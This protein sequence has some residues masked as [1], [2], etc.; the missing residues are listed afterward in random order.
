MVKAIFFDVLGT[1]VDWNRGLSGGFDRAFAKSGKDI[2]ASTLATAWYRT[3]RA[4]LASSAGAIQA[5]E[6]LAESL[7][8]VLADADLEAPAGSREQEL[9]L[10]CWQRFPAWPDSV[11]G[12]R[13]LRR[14][15]V[16]ASCTD[17]PTAPMTWLAKHAGLPWDLVLGSDL[18]DGRAHDGSLFLKAAATLDLLPSEVMYASAHN[19][20]LAAAR[21]VGLK[22][23]F[24]A[25]PKEFGPE[26]R[27]DLAPR[28]SWDI[29]AFDLLD[30]ARYMESA[31]Y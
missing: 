20:D 3:Y 17:L 28:D 22:T 25:R 21:A 31:V 16:I 24:F 30:L 9:L 13:A 7:A 12:L 5:Q 29:V 1:I 27:N 10:A 11:P 19:A 6:H 14:E 2:A 23:A 8:Q 26:Q 18:L 4:R 15:Y